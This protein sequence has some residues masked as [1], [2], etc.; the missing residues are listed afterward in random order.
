LENRG[1]AV[2]S[3]DQKLLDS[4]VSAR[5]DNREG[6]EKRR[7]S[8]IG[9]RGE[10]SYDQEFPDKDAGLL[11]QLTNRNDACVRPKDAG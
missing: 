1:V 5:L 11:G 9:V 8:A 7:G 6:D 2:A 3:L 4:E 10:A